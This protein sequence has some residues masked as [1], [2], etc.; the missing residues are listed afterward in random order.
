[1]D[2]S[3]ADEARQEGYV[4]RRAT[5]VDLPQVIRLNRENLPENYS[6]DFL[7][8]TLISNPESFFVA[9]R[10]GNIVGYIMCRV[11]FGFTS[12]SGLSLTRKGHVIS[13]AV[14]SGHRGRGIGRS[15]MVKAMEGLRG[16]GCSEVYL[17]VRVSNAPAIGLYESLGFGI[18]RR[19][20]GYY[21]DGEDA[22]VMARKL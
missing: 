4:I 3:L 10:D 18:V 19:I 21:K 22:Y 11:E 16:G 13:I 6:W 14:D 1:M 7:R 8:D 15:L 17:E 20:S 2:G 5:P 9:E 12:L